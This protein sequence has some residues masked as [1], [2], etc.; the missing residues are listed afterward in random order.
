MGVAKYPIRRGEQITTSYTD[1]TQSTKVRRKLLSDTWGFWCQCPACQ[2]P[3][4]DESFRS[5]FV[6]GL[7]CSGPVIPLN[8]N[9]IEMQEGDQE[10][11]R[12]NFV[13]VTCSQHNP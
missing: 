7:R 11:G 4:E 2:D 8:T 12:G 9:I 3:T 6:C 10:I 13:N 5:A 1:T